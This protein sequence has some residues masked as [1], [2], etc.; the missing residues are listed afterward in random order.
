[1]NPKLRTQVR[2]GRRDLMLLVKED[3]K[4]IEVNVD[5]FGRLPEF[6]FNNMEMS[7]GSPEGRP[8][9]SSSSS[10]SSSGSSSGGDSPAMGRKGKELVRENRNVAK[11][12]KQRKFSHPTLKHFCSY[13]RPLM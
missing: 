10:S 13:S 12:Y 2:L 3:K 8:K 6:D 5:Y 7:P 11:T 1:M 9:G 4:W